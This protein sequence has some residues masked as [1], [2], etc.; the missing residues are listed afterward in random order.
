MS[1]TTENNIQNQQ[2]GK[3]MSPKRMSLRRLVFFVGVFFILAL[4]IYALTSWGFQYGW[5]GIALVLSGLC[6]FAFFFNSITESNK[7]Q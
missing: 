7:E 6:I 1:F 5:I 3:A 2:G 4:G